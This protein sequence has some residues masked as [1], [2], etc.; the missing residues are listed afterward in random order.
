MNDHGTEHWRNVSL[1]QFLCVGA[2]D[3]RSLDAC[4]A[5]FA[6]IHQTITTLATVRRVASEVLDDFAADNVRYLELRTTPRALSDADA[7]GCVRGVLAEIARSE[8]RN[9]HLFDVREVEGAGADDEH[10]AEGATAPVTVDVTGAVPPGA[11]P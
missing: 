4:F 11:R 10:D 6:A 7:E 1:V 2:E 5:I 8:A 9:P 3:D